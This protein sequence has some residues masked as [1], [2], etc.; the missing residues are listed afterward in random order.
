MDFSSIT[1]F[2]LLHQKMKHHASRQEVIAENFANANTPGY[3]RKDIDKPDFGSMVGQASKNITLKTTDPN[4]IQMKG[5]SADSP[6]VTNF[7]V[8]P[9]L[10]AIQMT[11]NSKEFGAATA[12]YKKMMQLVRD[13]FGSG[14]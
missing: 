3:M 13:S 12:S 4:H 5:S 2:N 11:A 7:K 10:E 14:Q 6:I 9:D 1:S 8:Q